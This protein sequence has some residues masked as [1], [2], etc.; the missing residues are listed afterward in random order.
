MLRSIIAQLCGPELPTEVDELYKNCNY[1]RQQP[2]EDILVAT[3]IS[4]LS[5]G[6]P[7][8]LVM[9]ALDECLERKE[10]LKTIRRIIQTQSEVHVN[11]LA[12]SREEQDITEGM[13]SVI[14]NSI[15]LECGGLDAD[16][17]RHIHKC[18]ENDS[19]WQNCGSIIKQEIHEALV[20]GAHGM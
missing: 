20:K 6:H 18:L 2:G 14:A 7:T 3:L 4:L 9:D 11:M 12:T 16:I 5:S 15:S 8:Y 1:G 17:E 10:L 19:E 13:H